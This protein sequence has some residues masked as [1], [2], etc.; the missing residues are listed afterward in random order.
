MD[1][2]VLINFFFIDL[3][4]Q[5]K[6]FTSEEIGALKSFFKSHISRGQ[7]PSFKDVQLAKERFDVLKSRTDASIRGKISFFIRERTK[8][9]ATN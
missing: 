8:N 6:K 3:V 2:S 5:R 4:S 1:F 9:N 7:V